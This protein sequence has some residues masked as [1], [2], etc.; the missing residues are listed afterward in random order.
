MK[1]VSLFALAL[2]LAAPQLAAAESAGTPPAGCPRA[3]QGFF[4]GGN[5]GYGISYNKAQ[6]G[7]QATGLTSKNKIGARGVDGGIN[8]GY[9]RRFGAHWGTGLEF[10]ANWANTDG[11][12]RT[13]TPVDMKMSNKLKNS[14][15]VRANLFYVLC[16]EQV[17]PKVFLGW[18][19][20]DWKQ[21]F[22]SG[23]NT[24]SHSKRHNAFLWGAGV[25]FLMTKHLIMGFEYSGTVAQKKGRRDAAANNVGY[26]M[27]PQY[28]KVA[29]TLKVIY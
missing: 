21:Q 23:G 16:G 25:D 13:Y 24:S 6:F 15:E 9:N 11:S 22:V 2:T 27:K 28:N 10:V 4:L 5:L 29:W 14:L 8:V 1:K 20:Q 18:A 17:A 19:S 3:F 26:N 7:D 12:W